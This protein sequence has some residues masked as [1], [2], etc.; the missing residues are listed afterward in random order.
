MHRWLID[1]YKSK[2]GMKQGAPRDTLAKI[3]PED[4]IMLGRNYDDPFSQAQ[5]EV[6]AQEEDVNITTSKIARFQLSK[7]WREK[8]LKAE[9]KVIYAPDFDSMGYIA[10]NSGFDI[11]RALRSNGVIPISKEE[12][13]VVSDRLIELLKEIKTL[14]NIKL[15]SL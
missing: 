9:R 14:K 5:K 11:N 7:S 8:L 2:V 12:S 10:T 13:K 4:V 1:K 6:K 15:G 3:L